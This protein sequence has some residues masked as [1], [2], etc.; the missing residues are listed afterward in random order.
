M[1]ELQRHLA[2]TVT[3]RLR[4]PAT[5][6]A[7]PPQNPELYEKYRTGTRKIGSNDCIDEDHLTGPCN[8]ALGSPE[9][10]CKTHIKP[11]TA[12][13]FS[14][15]NLRVV[16]SELLPLQ[17]QPTFTSLSHPQDPTPGHIMDAK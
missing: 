1:R 4:S 10:P 17:N 9:P 5:V 11:P 13:H 8:N 16:Y 2:R 6:Q 12:T 7:S 14:P 3:R 15:H